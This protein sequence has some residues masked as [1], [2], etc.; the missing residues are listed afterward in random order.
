MIMYNISMGFS[1]FM[2]LNY[3]ERERYIQHFH[4]IFS[5]NLSVFLC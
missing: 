3:K 1:K 2:I 4:R 5:Y